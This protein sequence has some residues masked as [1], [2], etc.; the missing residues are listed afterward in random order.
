ML[1]SINP[2]VLQGQNLFAALQRA[3]GAIASM[4]ERSQSV[5]RALY[6]EL[7][8]LLDRAGSTDG[9]AQF[10]SLRLLLFVS[11]DSEAEALRLLRADALLA[12]FKALPCLAADSQDE[13]REMKKRESSKSVLGRLDM[14]SHG[15]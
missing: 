8:K 3:T 2:H 4:S 1:A 12:A 10:E 15:E 14:A 9:Q 11:P 6:A 7:K 13:L 5:R